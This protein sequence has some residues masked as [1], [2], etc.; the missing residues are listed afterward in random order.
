M[1]HPTLGSCLRKGRQACTRR[2]ESCFLSVHVLVAQSCLTLCNPM[3]CSLPV[4]SVHEI[5]QA[6]ILEWVAFS[7]S[8][9][10]SQPRGQTRVSC[11]AG[12]VFTH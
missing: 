7:F 6:K 9:G 10:S 12:G 3:D 4:S 8:W 11:T 5:F 2:S 1:S